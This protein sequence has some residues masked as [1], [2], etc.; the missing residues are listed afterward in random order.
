MGGTNI[1]Q[2]LSTSKEE[3]SVVKAYQTL[4]LV[5]MSVSC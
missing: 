2:A 5:Q 4:F 3:G 1:E